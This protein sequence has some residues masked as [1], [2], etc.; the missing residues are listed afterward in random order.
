MI[1]CS[2]YTAVA[3]E[4]RCL[5]AWVF[6]TVCI[7]TTFMKPFKFTMLLVVIFIVESVIGLFSY[8][9]QEQL[10]GDL[11]VFLHLHLSFS[12]LHLPI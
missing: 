1:F 12:Y 9:Y 3:F 5:L 8:V 11:K 7:L 4:S 6:Y 10:E 2:G